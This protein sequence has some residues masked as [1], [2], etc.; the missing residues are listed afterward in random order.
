MV[1]G[2]L[3]KKKKKKAPVKKS[4]KK[5]LPAKKKPKP[6]KKVV[7]KAPKKPLSLKAKKPAKVKEVLIG[8]ITHFFPRVSAGV[9]KLK[10]DLALGDTIR[11][12]GHTS[13]F[14]QK[15]NSL[16]I[17]NKPVKKASKGKLVGFLSK[18]RVRRSDKVYRVK[19]K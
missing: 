4:T 5:S 11:I 1:F 12:K 18:Q 19:E 14:V 15:V 6:A 17:D 2:F 9:I 3:F 10:T 16:Q 13:D 8:R 7:K